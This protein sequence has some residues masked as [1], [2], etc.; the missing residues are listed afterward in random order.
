MSNMEYIESENKQ[1]NKLG[2]SDENKQIQQYFL[3]TNSGELAKMNFDEIKINSDEIFERLA[4]DKLILRKKLLDNQ[5]NLC[6]N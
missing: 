3:R 1:N 6:Y 4:T 2:M 5:D